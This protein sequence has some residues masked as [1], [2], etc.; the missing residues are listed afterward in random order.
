MMKKKKFKRSSVNIY[1]N[2]T[3]DIS[4][5]RKKR[6]QMIELLVTNAER[7]L[8]KTTKL[9]KDSINANIAQLKNLL[10]M[11]RSNVNSQHITIKIV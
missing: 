5:F 9:K 2:V 10:N 7:N 3:K 8:L 6:Q 4:C 1:V 11:R